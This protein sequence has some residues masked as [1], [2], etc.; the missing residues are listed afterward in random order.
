MSDSTL[1]VLLV[2][3]C[4]G[5]LTGLRTFTPLTVLAWTLHLRFMDIPGS[6][7]HFLHTWPAVIILTILALAELVIDKLPSTPSR[8]KPPGMIGRVIFGFLCGTV[9][10]QAWGA[11]LATCAAIGLVCAIFGALVGYE[12]RR[13]WVRSFHWH[14]VPVALI[15]DVVAIGGSILIVSRAVLLSYK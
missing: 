1:P 13:G 8:L 3:A 10:A 7:L 9:S 5:G 6:P 11:S 4:L 2:A 14:D 15:E 12:V